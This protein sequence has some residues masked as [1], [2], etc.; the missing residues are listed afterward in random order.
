[1]VK[2][3]ITNSLSKEPT[4]L[5]VEDEPS[6]AIVISAYLKNYM[7]IDHVTDGQTAV[8]FCK[9]KKYDAVFMDIN[10]KGID[11]VETFKQIRTIDNHYANIPVVALTA[12]AMLGDREKF[13]SLGFTHYLSKPFD[14]SQLLKL[15][16]EV[17]KKN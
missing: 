6:N 7:K 9:S 14:R 11:G 1:M 4:V 2:N 15:M 16:K 13:L 8:E 5:L 3:E 10:L 17:L 12:Y